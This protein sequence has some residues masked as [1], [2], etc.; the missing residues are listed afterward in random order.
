MVLKGIQKLTL[1]DYPG[2]TACTLFTGGCNFRCPFCHNASLVIREGGEDRALDVS[3][4]LSFLSKRK[5]LLD[6]VV[7]TGGEPLLHTDLADLLAA[8]R[9]LGYAIKLDTNGAYP[10]R[11]A[12]VVEAGLVDYVAMDVKNA[13]ERYGRT[14]GIPQLDLAPIRE[15]VAFLLAGR[16]EFEFRTTVVRGLHF[17]GDFTAIGQWIAGAPRYFLQGFRDSG[18]LIDKEGRVAVGAFS[19]EEMEAFRG[20]VLPYVPNAALRGI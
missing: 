6:G 15:S 20:E 9:E 10:A 8:I 13:P 12:R 3:E 17:P 2:R 1:L 11:L 5:G 19:P 14:V 4:V 18:D 16:V 7:V